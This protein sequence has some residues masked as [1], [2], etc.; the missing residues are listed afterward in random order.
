MK[1]KVIILEVPESRL[2]QGSLSDFGAYRFFIETNNKQ[3]AVLLEN[4][5]YTVYGVPPDSDRFTCLFDGHRVCW[6]FAWPQVVNLDIDYLRLVFDYVLHINDFS[7]YYGGSF[8]K[9]LQENFDLSEFF[10]ED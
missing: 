6:V 2:D 5:L 10:K 1:T 4:M 9:F 3:T 8:S 7:K